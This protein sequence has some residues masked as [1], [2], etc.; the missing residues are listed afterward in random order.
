MS[1]TKERCADCGS[2]KVAH[3][4]F[5]CGDL[6]PMCRRCFEAYMRAAEERRGPRWGLSR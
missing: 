2:R 3:H 1:Q 6:L 5:W 4:R